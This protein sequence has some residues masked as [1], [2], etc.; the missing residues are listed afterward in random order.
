[1]ELQCGERKD[2][3]RHAAGTSGVPC[4]LKLRGGSVRS[5]RRGGVSTS[6]TDFLRECMYC[7]NVYSGQ[8]QE[9]LGVRIVH[10]FSARTNLV[11]ERMCCANVCS[12]Q[13]HVLCDVHES[14]YNSSLCNYHITELPNPQKWAPH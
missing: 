3:E 14:L 2:P 5:R 6:C 13:T 12:V 9:G 11:H 1:M 10:E 8:T 4:T 7:A